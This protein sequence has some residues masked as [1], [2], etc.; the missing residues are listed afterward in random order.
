MTP[1]ELL[2]RLREAGIMVPPSGLL[3][4]AQAAEVLGRSTVTLERWRMQS[5]G[6]RAVRL[7]GRYHYD[8][9][10]I[11]EYLEGDDE[12]RT[13]PHKPSQPRTTAVEPDAVAG[14]STRVLKLR[15]LIR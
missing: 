5:R 14:E 11:A 9:A 7:N 4:A 3:S 10:S 2:R 1:E 13:T 12:A 8:V 15:R 6:P